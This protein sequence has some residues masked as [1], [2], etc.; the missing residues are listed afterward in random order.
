MDLRTTWR[1]WLVALFGV[2]FVVDSF[3]YSSAREHT[4]IFWSFLLVGALV[5]IGGLWLALS[6]QRRQAWQA[7]AVA[8][9]SAYMAVSPWVLSFSSHKID[10]VLTLVVGLLGVIA[11]VWTAFA[12]PPDT[13]PA[14]ATKSTS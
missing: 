2:W 9:L 5:L 3:A 11:G 10:T 8:V 14:K 13:S 4:S 12:A 7:W 6:P 1:S